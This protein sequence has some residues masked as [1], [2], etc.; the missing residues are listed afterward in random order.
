VIRFDGYKRWVS[1][2][3]SHDPAQNWVLVSSVVMVVGLVVSMLVRRRRL[4]VRLAPDNSGGGDFSSLRRT[5]V[6]VA[7]LARTDQAG[8]GDGFDEQARGL[9]VDGGRVKPGKL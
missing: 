2:Q 7:G 1:M 6:E 5:V 4:W 9:T 8:W 3:V